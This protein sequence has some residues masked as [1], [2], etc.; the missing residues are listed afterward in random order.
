[1]PLTPAADSLPKPVGDMERAFPPRW[2]P[3]TNDSRGLQMIA[4]LVE[5]PRSALHA[6][7]LAGAPG[8]ADGGDSGPAL[9]AKARNEYRA[10]LQALTVARDEAEAWGDQG[11]L[12]QLGHEIEMLTAQLER[13]FGLGGRAR[14]IGAASERARSNV[15]RR[16]THGIEQLRAASP[17][18]AD[19]LAT[20]IR[21]G[22]YCVYEPP[23]EVTAASRK[24]QR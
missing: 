23:A 7:D 21:T 17:Q 11:R 24:S 2:L 9:D 4:R 1:M 13:A 14:K 20:T 5:Q 12:A 22:T 19:Y 18:L 8:A 10:R 16:I 15:Q 3:N 6:L